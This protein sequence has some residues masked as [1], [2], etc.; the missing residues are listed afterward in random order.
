[1]V[2]LGVRIKT[3]FEDTVHVLAVH[4]DMLR[5]STIQKIVFWHLYKRIAINNPNDAVK[6]ASVI[7]SA[8]KPLNYGIL[9]NVE[10][11]T[12]FHVYPDEVPTFDMIPN[13]FVTRQEYFNIMK[14]ANRYVFYDCLFIGR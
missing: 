12:V 14:W 1:M 5:Q 10:N 9:T 3:K 7:L 8:K 6:F 4:S 2:Y 13:R 11:G